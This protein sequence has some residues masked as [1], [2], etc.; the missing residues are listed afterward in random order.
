[1]A[2][3][4]WRVALAN[5]GRPVEQQQQQHSDKAIQAAVSIFLTVR[6][7]LAMVARGKQG[8]KRQG[9]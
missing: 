3:V 7:C 6:L 1:M 2:E 5:H 9:P 8:C 4:P